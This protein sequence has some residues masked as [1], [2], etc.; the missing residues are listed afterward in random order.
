MKKLLSRRAKDFIKL[1]G[2][3]LRI[4]CVSYYLPPHDRIGAGYQ[5][6]YMANAYVRA[7]HQVTMFS[8]Y[9]VPAEDTLYDM[10][11]VP[12]GKHNRTF[13]F[14]WNLRHQDFSA[15]DMIHAAGDDYCLLGKKRPY[16]V[17][18]MH[19]SCLKEMLNTKRWKQKIRMG[20][21]G[22]SEFAVCFVA[23]QVVCVSH[24]ALRDVPLADTVIWNG[25]DLDKFTPADTKSPNPSILFVG[26]LDS[27]KRGRELLEIFQKQIRPAIPNAELWIVREDQVIDSPGV[28]SLGGV[29]LEKLVELYQSAW[30]F[31]LPSS[32]EGFGVPYIEAMASGTAVVAAP[33]VG[34]LE[35][36][37]K[38]RYG[39]VA[40]LPELGDALIK[41]L[42][43][44]AEREKWVQL[45]LERAETFSW[46]KVVAAY[47]D[48]A[49]AQ[50]RRK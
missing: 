32:Y 37:E 18:S 49:N 6:H 38:G 47:L 40:D 28:H 2:K 35:V 15:F 1:T 12:I 8:P 24:N 10:V 50:A 5:M 34:A 25:V 33:N 21:L 48:L 7:G 22:L 42:Q 23:D 11:K 46:K 19:G 26:V 31:C 3:P 36:L 30:V 43:N 14:A 29:S 20:I 44:P 16:H 27:R 4:A 41:L 17:R 13:R 39:V 45:G 9:D